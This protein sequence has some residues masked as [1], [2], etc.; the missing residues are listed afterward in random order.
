MRERER[1][2]EREQKSTESIV[3]LW[4]KE[5]TNSRVKR[6]LT[7]KITTEAPRVR[8][9]ICMDREDIKKQKTRQKERHEEM[10]R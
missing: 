4:A 1:E 9:Q 7:K 6:Q 2:R 10:M 3:I 5:Y 8:Q